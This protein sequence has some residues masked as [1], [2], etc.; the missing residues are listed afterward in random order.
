MPSIGDETIEEA[1]EQADEDLIG[2]I[3]PAV[4]REALKGISTLLP[5]I[6]VMAGN[7]AEVSKVAASMKPLEPVIAGFAQYQ[8]TL[9]KGIGYTTGL[10]N[11]SEFLSQ[12]TKVSGLPAGYDIAGASQFVG[13]T[14]G[15]F[16]AVDAQVSTGLAAAVGAGMFNPM[17][18]AIGDLQ[19]QRYAGIDALRGHYNDQLTGINGM[20][21][22]SLKPL[23][24][25]YGLTGAAE[26]M[27]LRFAEG[28]PPNWTEEIE[29]KHFEHAEQ[30]I[31][32]EGIPLAWVPR[33]EILLGLL[34][35][36]SREARIAIVLEHADAIADDCLEA[37]TGLSSPF[38]GHA[39]LARDAVASF[40]AGFHSPAM[41][42]A[43]NV[44]ESAVNQHMPGASHNTWKLVNFPLEHVEFRVL[45]GFVALKSLATFYTS[46][47]P[48]F[49]RPRPEALSRHVIAHALT[50]FDEQPEEP[51]IALMHVAS[52]LR[53]LQDWIDHDLE[54]H[55]AEAKRGAKTELRAAAREAAEGQT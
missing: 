27:R 34:T 20:L 36:S 2:Q 35:A 12:A 53:G 17:V 5:A 38:E 18:T 41:A 3:D 51:I 42:L 37:L 31:Q 26:A 49:G 9:R 22:A 6:D 14:A 44:T 46:W 30:I 19:R 45:R 1:E 16:D 43:V 11:L 47:N 32:T 7:R 40:K 33:E 13:L 23:E 10:A 24:L 25:F 4:A 50:G 52:I 54:R 55:A 21:S 15:I 8:E 29:L 48:K 39:R 28:R